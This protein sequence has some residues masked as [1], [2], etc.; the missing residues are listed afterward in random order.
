MQPDFLHMT[1]ELWLISEG[2]EEEEDEDRA[3][4][5]GCEQFPCMSFGARRHLFGISIESGLEWAFCPSSSV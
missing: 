4:D 1:A 2:G 3:E 5:V